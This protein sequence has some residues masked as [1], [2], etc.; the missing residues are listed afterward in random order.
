MNKL[1]IIGIDSMSPEIFEKLSSKMPNFSKLHFAKLKT[2]IPPE[3]PVAW[4]AACTGC[5][6]GKYGIF[7][8]ISR[9]VQTYSP[10]L[11]LAE[12]KKSLIN[13]EYQC[14]MK[15]TPFWRI[16]SEKNIPVVVLRWPV[17]FPSEK[18]NG[19]MLSGLG[20]VDLKGM[21]NSY[22]FYTNEDENNSEGKEKV[23]KVEI[24][25]NFIE[26]Y[27]SGPLVYKQGELT[28]VKIPMFL[29]IKDE[30]LKININGE[31]YF[32]K[33][34]SWSDFIR[35]KFKVSMFRT[36]YG[37]FNLY[38]ESLRP[39]RMY[40]SSIQIDPENQV[41]P[42]TYPENYGKI[43][44][45]NIG[46][47]HTLGMPED[48]KAVTEKKLETSVFLEQIN[49]IETEREKMFWY[50]FENFKK[51]VFSFVFD[52]GDRLTH[53]FWN[54][55]GV[56]TPEIEKYYLNKDK[57]LGK[58]IERLDDKTRLIVFSDHGFSNFTKQVSINKWLI[59]KGYMECDYS[60]NNSLL[61]FVNWKKTKA[62]ALGFT[63]VYL[64]LI[65]REKEGCVSEEEKEDLLEELKKNL[66]KLK[67]G[68]VNVLTNV[69]KSTDVYKGEYLNLA[70]D[71]IL[72]FAPG[73]RMSNKSVIGELDDEIIFNNT[74][75]WKGDHLI[76]STHVPGV[77]FTNF[78]INKENPEI[79]DIAPTILKMFGVSIPE[80]I[81][82]SSLV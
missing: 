5:N 57:F 75:E 36:V 51:G 9:N 31:E 53:I 46:L 37:I 29:T 59:E 12:E 34:K 45:E 33:T 66:L 20:V 61:K 69:Y 52:A 2:T 15:G 60:K 25:N 6:P 26:T 55:E 79:I 27:I 32:L 1:V 48:T 68:E 22:S 44:V 7:D 13:T 3:T 28:A 16:L 67:D 38:L 23:I 11:N 78:K 54:N 56:L 21:L 62:Y 74:S 42:I 65:G 24:K 80:N 39:F 58:I 14:S 17:T 41:F 30:E 71:L 81:D 10:K 18:I 35:V 72:G 70:P 8:F 73:Y 64:N 63:S 77:L 40:M 50:E 49:Q 19:R 4:S 76:D 82:G 43:L 47:F